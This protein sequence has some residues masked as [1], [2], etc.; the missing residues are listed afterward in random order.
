MPDLEY[1][2]TSYPVYQ[3]SASLLFLKFPQKSIIK[4]K[5]CHAYNFNEKLQNFE[6]MPNHEGEEIPKRFLYQ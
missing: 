4:R 2:G 3:F 1:L 6:M 5:I